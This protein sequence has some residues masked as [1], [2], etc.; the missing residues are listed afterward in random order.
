MSG[1]LVNIACDNKASLFFDDFE[2]PESLMFR[3]IFQY[4]QLFDGNV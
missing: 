3:S 2:F 4:S 1:K